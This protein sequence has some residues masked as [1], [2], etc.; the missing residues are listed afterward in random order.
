MQVGVFQFR[1]EPRDG[2]KWRKASKRRHTKNLDMLC[3]WCQLLT[4]HVIIIFSKHVLMK[5]KVN[6]N[7]INKIDLYHSEL[8]YIR[9]G[10]NFQNVL[11]SRLKSFP[12]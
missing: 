11:C 2:G 7:Y 12:T 6:K 5:I 3:E 4:I 8:K 1:R 10:V 9:W